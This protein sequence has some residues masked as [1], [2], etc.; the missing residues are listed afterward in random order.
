MK[1]IKLILLLAIFSI[2]V[3]NS[4]TGEDEPI[5]PLLLDEVP[6][7]CSQP[8]F[9]NVS[10]FINGN[11]V[12]IDWDKTSGDE[13]E[14]QYGTNGFVLGT[15]TIVNFDTTSSLITGLTST[16]NYSFYIRTICAE[17][18]YSQWIGPIAPGSSLDVCVNPTNLTAVRSATDI[19]KIT[20]TWSANGDENSWQVQYGTTG[21]VIGSGTIVATASPTKTV[22]SLLGNVAYD[23][24]VRSNCDANQNSGWVGPVT[25]NAVGVLGCTTPTNLAVVRNAT[26]SSQ[27][28][29]SWTAGGSETSWEIQYGNTGFA[30]GTGTS[31][32]ATTNPKIITGLLDTSYDFYIRAKCSATQNSSWFGPINIPAAGST[33]GN[34]YL[35]MKVDGVL[36]NFPT[37]NA[38]TTYDNLAFMILAINGVDSFSLQLSDPIGPGTYAYADPDVFAICVYNQNVSSY[39]SSY[40]DFTNSIGSIII[41]ELNTTNNTI[42]GTFNFNG[43]NDAMT[44]TKVITEG[45][46]F[47]PF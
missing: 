41:T 29:V 7:L 15:G 23:F 38:N 34:Y 8:A 12:R 37:A 11:T 36:V 14:I 17:N 5:D 22:S 9:F 35:R 46:F 20:A 42:K 3:F 28:N 33:G 27:V 16:T 45:E 24:Y 39:S 43:K 40:E 26:M 25:V 31:S 21:F 18:E 1:S 4:C 30:V 13:W 44:Q 10:S 32:V 19:T 2:F 47:L 6:T